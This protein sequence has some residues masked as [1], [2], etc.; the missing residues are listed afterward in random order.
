MYVQ[1][2]NMHRYKIILQALE[3]VKVLHEMIKEAGDRLTVVVGK[4]C[5]LFRRRKRQYDIFRWQIHTTPSYE[6][7]LH[8]HISCTNYAK[9]AGSG[10][11]LA[12]LAE[13]ISGTNATEFHG[14]FSKS[15]SQCLDSSSQIAMG[16]ADLQPLKETSKETVEKIVAL[17]KSSTF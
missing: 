12:C 4:I 16:A 1:A 5:G 9:F 11:S 10:V 2:L 6:L 17:L 8:F 3:G 7:V 13:L 15:L 14:S